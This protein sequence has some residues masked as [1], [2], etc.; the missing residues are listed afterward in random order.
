MKKLC[1]YHF[2]LII[3]CALDRYLEMGLLGHM[4]DF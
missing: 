1:I 2:K 4:A 3:L